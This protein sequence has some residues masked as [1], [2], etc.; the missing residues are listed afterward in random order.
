MNRKLLEKPFAPEQIKQRDGNFDRTLDY[1]EG[2]T[3]IQRLNDAFDAQWSFE[4]LK[5]EIL[6][7]KD[8]VIVQGKLTAENVVKTQFGS[9]QITRA[10]DTSEI[11]SLA[12]DLKAAATDFLKK[13]ATML[14]V[15]LHLY[16]GDRSLHDRTR[17]DRSGNNDP[18][19]GNDHQRGNGG[20]G[21]GR[22]TNKQL[23]YIVNLGKNLKWDSKDLDE[24]SVRIFG[25][26]M[27]YLTIKDASSFIETLKSKTAQHVSD[28]SHEIRT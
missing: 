6:E 18:G 14:G 8:E 16:N 13:C 4:I 11:I 19:W 25:V 27:A 1:V 9:S 28:L 24:E 20:N 12:D 5:H 10:R 17:Q 15:G 3:V 7:D 26:K 22:I 2:H 21:D 23:N